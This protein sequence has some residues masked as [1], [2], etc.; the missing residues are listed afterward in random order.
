M[1]KDVILKKLESLSRCIDR[2]ESKNP[3]SLDI[4]EED[5]D[6]QDVIVLNLER[7]VQMCVD[8]GMHVLSSSKL[9]LPDTMGDT[10]AVLSKEGIIS[11]LIS[12]RMIKSVGFRNIA[13][14]VY[15]SIDWMI[16]DKI[17]NAHLGDFRQF[18]KEIY[19]TL[20]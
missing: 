15:Q 14:H 8:I 4:L 16:V 1:D 20:S 12:E 5:L 19:A 17:I 13:V 2:I 10:F 6:L 3:H 18:T 11:E 9:P 7:A